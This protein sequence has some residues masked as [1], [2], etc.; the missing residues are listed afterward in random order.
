[1]IVIKAVS[2]Q[3]IQVNFELTK[4]QFRAILQDIQ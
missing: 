1:M 3:H 4:K 2:D